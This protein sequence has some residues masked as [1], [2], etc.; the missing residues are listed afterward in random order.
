MKRRSFLQWCLGILGVGTAGVPAVKAKSIDY[1]KT[2]E[3]KNENFVDV[4]GYEEDLGQS[5][6]EIGRNVWID[7]SAPEKGDG[8]R[9]KPFNN[10]PDANEH[11]NKHRSRG[12]FLIAKAPQVETEI[13]IGD[14]KLGA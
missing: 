14:L 12:I 7:T 3:C 4:W 11:I 2:T 9:A 1:V 6:E 5:P 13:V 10:F 8:S